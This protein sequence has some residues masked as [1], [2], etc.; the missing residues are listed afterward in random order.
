M[1]RSDQDQT[2]GM[3]LLRVFDRVTR[4]KIPVSIDGDLLALIADRDLNHRTS[5]LRFA[6]E[7]FLVAYGAAKQVATCHPASLLNFTEDDPI[8]PIVIV[9]DRKDRASLLGE[10]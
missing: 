10:I 8:K 2:V 1:S 4:V 7:V 5:L 3:K 6:R 9:I